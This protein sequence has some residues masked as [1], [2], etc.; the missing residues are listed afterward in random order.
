VAVHG[1]GSP[2]RLRGGGRCAC[3]SGRFLPPHLTWP[4]Q[5]SVAQALTG[6]LPPA[7][8]ASEGA[9]RTL[10]PMRR[11]GR[12]SGAAAPESGKW[13]ACGIVDNAPNTTFLNAGDAFTILVCPC[14]T[15]VSLSRYIQLRCVLGLPQPPPQLPLT[16]PS[17]PILLSSLETPCTTHGGSL[18]RARAPPPPPPPPPLPPPRAAQQ[19][20]G[21]AAGASGD[22]A[23]AGPRRAGGAQASR[24][25]GKGKRPHA[26]MDSSGA[27][28]GAPVLAVQ[29]AGGTGGTASAGHPA[30]AQVALPLP[31]SGGGA[32]GVSFS[33]TGAD[34][35]VAQ[36]QVVRPRR[37]S[38]AACAM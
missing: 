14:T 34:F 25:K 35:Q 4:M 3:R 8:P 6:R 17:A 32:Q 19:P 28:V 11:S 27:V 2:G 33:I 23:S 29:A 22:A 9:P 13:C 26:E 15:T 12:S 30:P 21:L 18:L 38:R 31:A 1:R 37:K 7:V 5:P 20:A 24:P 10:P 36:S 16:H